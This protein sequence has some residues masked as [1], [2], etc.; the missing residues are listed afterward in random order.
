MHICGR[1]HIDKMDGN[2]ARI[3]RKGELKHMGRKRRRKPGL[4]SA[5]KWVLLWVAVALTICGVLRVLAGPEL[6]LEF[7]G[8]YL[9]E[10]SL[11]MDNLFVFLS[12]FSAF[13]VAEHARH[14]VLHWGILGA[15]VLRLLFVLM[16]SAVV[17]RFSW[18]LYLFGALLLVNG[19]KMLR[20]GEEADP[21][22]SGVMRVIRSVLPMT[23]HFV[24]ERFWVW[25]NKTSRRVWRATPLLGV[26]LLIECS[27]ILFAM[28]SV[29][30]VFSM[31]THPFIVYT[32]NILAVLGLRQLYFVLEY[33]AEQF[34]YVRYGVAAILFFTGF[35]MLA[36]LFG[37]HI[38]T[39]VSI[40]LI[41]S[42]LCLS[43]L[44]S[45][46]AAAI[47]RRVIFFARWAGK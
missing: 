28:D 8:G 3:L 25:E 19:V 1:G 22:H 46:M 39:G 33:V 26:L 17:H 43:I 13:G 47:K 21:Q 38:G 35:K 27:D 32:S 7:L 36:V 2:D 31:S 20:G 6:A 29:P 30:A 44:A 15:I 24:G 23:D 10:L 16:G 37:V 45:V 11:S 41:G 42:I 18:V 4:L 9:I 12:I 34:Q 5:L 14:R 40:L